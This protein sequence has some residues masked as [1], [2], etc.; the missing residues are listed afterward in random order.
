MKQ[1]FLLCL[2]P[3]T[4]L[5]IGCGGGGGGANVTTT[6]TMDFSTSGGAGLRPSILN[7]ASSTDGTLNIFN[8]G[9][10]TDDN[11]IVAMNKLD[12]W[13]LSQ[14]VIMPMSSGNGANLAQP[15]FSTVAGATQPMYLLQVTFDRANQVP[16]GIAKVMIPGTDYTVLASEKNLFIIP[17]KPFVAGAYYTTIF[18]NLMMDTNGSALFSPSDYA[19]AKASA[20][21]TAT[22]QLMNALITAQEGLAAAIGVNRDLIIFTDTFKTTSNGESLRM[23]KLAASTI[24]ANAVNA[25]RATTATDVWST[26]DF[27]GNR[28]LNNVYNIDLTVAPRGTLTQVLTDTAANPQGAAAESRLTT[29]QAA[30]LN[31]SLTAAG[32]AGVA[33][34]TNVY[35]TTV[36]LPYFL[37]HP[38]QSAFA[39]G[40]LPWKGASDSLWAITRG[41]AAGG[42]R[43]TAITNALATRNVNAAN[44]SALYTDST[45]KGQLATEV[46]KLAGLNI[47]VP[48]GNGGNTALDAERNVTEY[49]ALPALTVLT[50]VPVLLFSPAPLANVHKVVVFQHGIT[51][52]KENV[53]SVATGIIAAGLAQA[54]N[55]AVLALDLPLHGERGFPGFLTD[56]AN[57]GVYANLEYLAVARDNI[58]QSAADLLGVRA[59]L[60]WANRKAAPSIGTQNQLKVSFFGHSLGAIVGTNFLAIANETTNYVNMDN[61]MFKVDETVLAMP[62]VQIAH[63]MVNS[64]T[65]GPVV[66][67]DVI[68]AANA[69]LKAAFDAFKANCEN[70]SEKT[71]FTTQFLKTLPADTQQTVSTTMTQFAFAAQTV[72]D[73]ADPV[74]SASLV[75]ATNPVYLIEVV[76]DKGTNLADQV[77]PNAAGV[78]GTE[79]LVRELRLN[80][81]TAT[82]AGT[83]HHVGRFVKGGHSSI[84]APDARFDAAG[85]AT[86]EMQAQVAAMFASNG[87]SLPIADQALLCRDTAANCLP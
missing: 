46:I 58:R 82:Q 85:Q 22:S 44:L 76:G 25:N 19:N 10:T 24:V 20:G 54:Q 16:N 73:A 77:I 84:I 3:F 83:V 13:S 51:S 67:H 18:T 6:N 68:T 23:V 64:P 59:A 40:V 35:K 28:A 75:A 63:I 32:L 21:N 53:Y 57:P 12:G 33:G 48:D 14:A 8:T 62:G 81:L 5:F 52:I 15:S 66:T 69:P 38:R 78:S 11:P 30:A 87:Q 47:Q 27:A 72:I 2:I 79:T 86:G 71:C 17:L 36:K 60:A 65:F 41:L 80:D 7:I 39:P 37:G 50:D 55:I 31:A 9:A 74:S 26:G 45:K 29:A 43:A 56:A 49:N 34:A 61:S 70:S 42:D 1:L 4:M